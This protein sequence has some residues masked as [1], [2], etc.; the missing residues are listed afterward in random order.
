MPENH[1]NCLI[2]QRNTR[3]VLEHIT[4]KW[5][6]LILTVLCTE[7]C[8][9]NEL[10]RRLDGITHKALA[11]ALKRLERNGLIDRH[12]LSTHPVS[13][14]YTI[15]PLAQSLQQPFIALANWAQEFGPAIALAQAEYDRTHAEENKYDR[16]VEA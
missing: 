6:I 14:E 8:R 11:D 1:D 2:E 4:N 7:P 10:R 9:F 5:S 3:L 16:R 12:V 15:T 13:V